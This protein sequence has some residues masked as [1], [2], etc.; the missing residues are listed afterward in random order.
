MRRPPGVQRIRKV[1]QPSLYP[2]GIEPWTAHTFVPE[3]KEQAGRH[4]GHAD[5][6]QVELRSPTP[7]RVQ[8]SDT[9]ALPA[10]TAGKAPDPPG[11]RIL[12]M[13]DD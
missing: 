2:G 1:V 8:S 3:G 6:G 12:L 4:E 13:T 10:S 5:H 9:Y 7:H 11:K